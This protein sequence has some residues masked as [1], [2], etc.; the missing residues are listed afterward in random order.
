MQPC[1]IPAK[2]RLEFR[3][4]AFIL[5]LRA[6]DRRAGWRSVS[7]CNLKLSRSLNANEPPHLA[8]L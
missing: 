6:E 7:N 8:I 3:R 5:C 4:A 2:S 1:Q